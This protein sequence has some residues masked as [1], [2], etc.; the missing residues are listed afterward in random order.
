M[1]TVTV[2]VLSWLRTKLGHQETGKVVFTVEVAEGE[3]VGGLMARLAAD[4]PGFREHVY[5]A[6]GQRVY[7]H[8]AVLL[9]GRALELAGGLAAPLRDGDRLVLLPGF[10]GG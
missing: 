3:T 5:D 7:E 9:N 1:T 10:A 8:V 4:L 6:S 2:E